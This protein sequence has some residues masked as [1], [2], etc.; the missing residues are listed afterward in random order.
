[1]IKEKQKWKGGEFRS[2]ETITH[3]CSNS[4]PRD[5]EASG[6]IN[7][8]LNEVPGRSYSEGDT[9]PGSLGVALIGK[10][11]DTTDHEDTVKSGSPRIKGYTEETKVLRNFCS[12]YCINGNIRMCTN[13]IPSTHYL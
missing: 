1:M 8:I 4:I 10:G 3:K 2:V 6:N 11:R 5:T 13:R 12:W 9:P 7:P